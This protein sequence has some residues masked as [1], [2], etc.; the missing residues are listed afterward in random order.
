MKTIGESAATDLGGANLTDV[1]QVGQGRKLLW[2]IGKQAVVD[3]QLCVGE[4][5]G[6]DAVLVIAEH[7]VVD[8]QCAALETDAGTIAVGYPGATE[9][10]VA[11]DKIP[12]AQHPDGLVF[13]RLSRSFQYR[14]R[15]AAHDGQSL[16]LPH[17]HIATIGAGQDQH[18][19]AIPGESRGLGDARHVTTS[20]DAQGGSVQGAGT[21]DAKQHEDDA[22]RHEKSCEVQES[23]TC[24]A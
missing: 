21:Q 6:Q 15:M 11:Y 23:E 17:R 13:C 9:F 22:T 5:G 19:V 24:P 20:A 16:L 7:A 8:L 14:S 18:G 12:C 1:K 2:C 3:A 10:D 4:V